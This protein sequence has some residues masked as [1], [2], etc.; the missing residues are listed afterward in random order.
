MEGGT[1]KT[2]ADIMTP[3]P[4][5]CAP[6]APLGAVARLMVQHNCGEVPVVDTDGQLIGVVTDRD[7]VCRVLAAGKN[8][9]EHTVQDCMSQ[10]PI[11][12]H[13]DTTL[14][15]V[16]TTMECHQIRRVPVVDDRER[17]VGIVAQAD[18]AWA[19]Q[20]KDVAVLVRE[21]SRDT[22]LSSR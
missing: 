22:D 15:D 21:V 2:A 6:D 8:P 19:G 1:M 14:T 10:P 20:Q 13:P 17:C 7:I 16:M 3:D 11:T 9:L 4:A 18:L 5:C 12:V